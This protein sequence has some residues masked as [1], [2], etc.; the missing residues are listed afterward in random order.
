MKKFACLFPLLGFLFS[1][2]LLFPRPVLAD[3]CSD[4]I[5]DFGIYSCGLICYPS[6]PYFSWVET[7][8]GDCSAMAD[9]SI[10]C[11]A[12]GGCSGT[13]CGNVSQWTWCYKSGCQKIANISIPGA[14]LFRYRY[15]YS[16]CGATDTCLGSPYLYAG[17]CSSSGCTV[18]G[19]YKVCCNADGTVD[20]NCNGGQFTGTCPSGTS[21]KFCGWGSY[22]ACDA[23]NVCGSETPTIPPGATP[24]P[25]AT[26]PPPQSCPYWCQN[27]G[28]P[29]PAGCTTESGTCDNGGPCCKCPPTPIPPTNCGSFNVTVPE[30]ICIEDGVNIV[31]RQHQDIKMPWI[32]VEIDQPNGTVLPPGVVACRAG[33]FSKPGGDRSCFWDT[34]H[35]ENAYN[36]SDFNQDLHPPNLTGPYPIPPN[37]YQ[38]SVVYTGF[39]KC[40]WQKVT[41]DTNLDYCYYEAIG[42]RVTDATKTTEPKGIAGVQI[43]VYNLDDNKKGDSVTNGNGYWSVNDLVRAGQLYSVRVTGNQAS[44]QTAP[45]GYLPPAKTNEAGWNWDYCDNATPGTNPRADT[46]LGSLSYECQKADSG[47]DCASDNGVRDKRCSF[48]Y[49]PSLPC[50]TSLNAVCNANG[51]AT[52]SWTAVTGAVSYTLRV[53]KDPYDVWNPVVVPPNSDGTRDFAAGPTTN[54]FTH[55]LAG[56]VNW[57]WSIHPIAVGEIYSPWQPNVCYAPILNCLAII[58]TSVPLVGWFQTTG[59]D[60]QAQDSISSPIPALATYK[61]LSLKGGGGSPGVVGYGDSLT[62]APAGE[63]VW[64]AKTTYAGSTIGFDYLANRLGVEKEDDFAGEDIDISALL[65]GVYYSSAETTKNISGVFPTDEKI[66]IFAVGDVKVADDIIV[67]PGDF[68]ALITKGDITFSGDPPYVV[69]KAQGF[70]LA[71]GAINILTS[72]NPDQ[73]FEG[74]GSFVGWGGINLTRDLGPGNQ[75]RNPAET[76]IERPDFY[77]NAPSS[78]KLT[79]SYFKE[80]EP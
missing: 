1:I 68:F 20:G 30:N 64:Q 31:V 3:E 42:G 8:M 73:D 16:N 9:E 27:A 17:Q 75:N 40:G 38:V 78:F 6:C 39:G 52:F 13:A 33:D 41:K 69:R 66:V 63:V 51:T 11:T 67:N 14:C 22:P 10:C 60:I 32:N 79:N 5:R 74:Q 55:P 23:P 44:P 43:E 34:M 57:Q 24:P 21:T 62:L 71:D 37:R 53:N 15:S 50:P 28:S 4:C 7:D 48:S 25:G 77:I 2:S 45:S 49:N 80:I 72:G 54:F 35:I 65:S 47:I 46:P 59:G 12:S 18:G 70:F 29:C 56:G 19:R 76:F 36:Y 58:P 26:Q 61:F